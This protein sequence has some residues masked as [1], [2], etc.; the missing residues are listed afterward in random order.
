MAMSRYCVKQIF[1]AHSLM[2]ERAPQDQDKYVVRFPEGL[3]DK[4]KASA[5][6]NGRSMNAEIIARLE[7]SFRAFHDPVDMV[8]LMKTLDANNA[9]LI[10]IRITPNGV[11][12]IVMMEK[13]TDPESSPKR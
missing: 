6:A 7:E 3:R 5:E 1:M 9:E 10:Q 11:R 12:E 2:T 4:V 8:E 13:K